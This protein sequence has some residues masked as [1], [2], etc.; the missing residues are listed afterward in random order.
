MEDTDV[1]FSMESMADIIQTLH[2]NYCTLNIS[3]I[4]KDT[5]NLDL[6]LTAIHTIYIC[7]KADLEATKHIN[8]SMSKQQQQQYLDGFEKFT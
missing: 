3:V 5:N 8:N 7:G 2:V 6:S 1:C 4:T